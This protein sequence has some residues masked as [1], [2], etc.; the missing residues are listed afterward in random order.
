MPCYDPKVRLILASASPRRADLLAAAGFVFDVRPVEVDE[1]PRNGEA[2]TDYVIRLALD[3][4]RACPAAPEDVV[5][6]ADTTVVVDARILAKPADKDDARGMLRALSGRQHEVLTGVALRHGPHLTSRS[7]STLVRFLTLTS[8]EI[9]WYLDSGEPYDKA[10]AYAV[11]GLASRFI[12][13]VE[14]SHANVVGLPVARLY[15]MLN[16]VLGRAA[17]RSLGA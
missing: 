16:D 12:E 11:Q 14:G 9:E 13:R 4:A 8:D 6:A 5:V 15:L 10:G 17:V 3:K 7:E 2:P 1:T